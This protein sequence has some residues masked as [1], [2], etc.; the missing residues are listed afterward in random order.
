MN[1]ENIN[2]LTKN[3]KIPIEIDS[4]N[5]RPIPKSWTLYKCF[6]FKTYFD[7]NEQQILNFD[8]QMIGDKGA[9]ELVKIDRNWN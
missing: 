7:L 8:S 4:V 1:S 6:F 3:T 2:C 5:C 9:T